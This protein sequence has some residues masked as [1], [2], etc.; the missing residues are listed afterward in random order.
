MHQFCAQASNR[1]LVRNSRLSSVRVACRSYRLHVNATSLLDKTAITLN[2]NKYEA[3]SQYTSIEN[4][5]TTLNS[6]H[7]IPLLGLG[8]WRGEAGQVEHAI[9]TAVRAGCR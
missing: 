3:P 8:T 4:P 5:T 9:E 1:L 7:K 2:A 6:G